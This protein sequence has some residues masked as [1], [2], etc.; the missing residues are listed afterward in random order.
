MVDVRTPAEFEHEHIAG[1]MLRPLERLDAAVFAGQLN[2]ED[3][4]VYVVCRGGTRA[5][6][7]IVKL[8]SAG[9]KNCVLLEG[10]IEAWAR[11]GYELQRGARKAIS[12]ERQV[13]IAAGS[14]VLIGLAL[15]FMVARGFFGLSAFVGAGLVFA[16]LTDFCGMGMLLAR[17]PWNQIQSNNSE[18][19]CQGGKWS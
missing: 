7:A 11:C 3:S 6:S 16:G 17:M 19:L 1:A 14:L 4:A 8:E 15:G 13:R 12:L 10:G 2:S 5:R 9:L 18:T